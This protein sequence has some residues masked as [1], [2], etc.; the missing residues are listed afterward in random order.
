MLTYCTGLR[1]DFAWA[2]RSQVAPLG[3]VFATTER[4][5]CVMVLRAAGRG[6]EDERE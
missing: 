1:Y 3:S 2:Y 5:P 4:P 6:D